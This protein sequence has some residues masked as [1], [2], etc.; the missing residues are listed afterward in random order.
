[1]H[2]FIATML[3]CCGTIHAAPLPDAP[4]AQEEARAIAYPE[5]AGTPA[6]LLWRD[7]HLWLATDR[8]VRVYKLNEGAWLD[9]PALAEL[10]PAFALAPDRDGRVLIGA[11]DGV[12][13]VD[14]SGARREAWSGGPIGAFRVPGEARRAAWT[15]YGPDGA[16]DAGARAARAVDYARSV[17]DAAV[18]AQGR[19]WLATGMGLHVL[20][21]G[22]RAR[23]YQGIG[24]ILSANVRAVAVDAVGR[25]WAGVLGGLSVYEDGK[26][27]RNLSPA[28]GVPHSEV[29]CVEIAP[30]GRVWV[31]T[32]AG[33]GRYD[34][35]GWSHRHSRRWL[36]ADDARAIAFSP[37]GTAYVA[38]TGGIG[39]ISARPMTL[40]EKSGHFLAA[41]KARHIR[42]PFIV[43]KCRL[44]TPGDLGTWKPEDDDNDGSYTAMFMVAEAFRFAVTGDAEAK[45]HADRA[46]DFLELLQDVTETPGFVARTVVPADW[47]RM[48]DMN[49]TFD[50]R[51]RAR[52]RVDD[53]RFKP[54]E[55]RWRPSADGQWLWKGDT[56]SDEITGH[57]WGYALYHDLAAD[58]DRKRRAAN[59]ARRVMDYL[60]AHDYNLIDPIDGLHTRWGVWSPAKLNHDPDWR[61][62]RGINSLEILSFLKTT[63]HL[64][65]DDKYQAAYL[66][67]LHNHGY[68]ENIREAKT[69]APA[70]ITH[71][72]T[73]LLTMAF[74]GVL[75]YETDPLL[76]AAYRDALEHW[77]RDVRVEQNPYA[78]MT[79]ALLTG[80]SPQTDA[81]LDVLRRTPLD[82]VNWVVD[83]RAREDIRPVRAPILE[84][85]NMDR[86]VPVDERPTIRWDKNPWAMVGGDGGHTAWA[87]SFWLL[88]YWMARYLQLVE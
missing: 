9:R 55:T 45:D 19:T 15:A 26:P 14:A 52:R 74:V 37:D 69:Y 85:W 1:M 48:H 13:E 58:A 56:S 75:R 81:A 87:P 28:D 62:E 6:R 73:E 31:G 86:L 71:I 83:Q 50:E 77:Y 82:L 39:V 3:I 11:W 64:T 84:D 72:D 4:F 21:G 27:T 2:R 30:D 70:W 33:V 53:P 35:V 67:L 59:L 23:L 54:V 46:F 24:E 41:V 5:G 44:E 42:A 22:G 40:A 60:M 12:H 51:E 34:G 57:F 29:Q 32:P 43:E 80:A 65:G 25:V 20:D 38:T 76:L 66:D 47:T 8:G 49:E 7:G 88:P 10:G 79:Y 63:H 68:L 61:A 18:D 36:P 78:D 16:V 17:R